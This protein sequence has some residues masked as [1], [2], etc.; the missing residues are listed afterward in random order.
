[1]SSLDIDKILEHWVPGQRW[2]GGKGRPIARIS[3]AAHGRL[4][5]EH[6][7]WLYLATV[8][9]SDGG[10]DQYF[11]PVTFHSGPAERLEHALIGEVTDEDGRAVWVYDAL[12]D[13]D[14]SPIWP[15]LMAEEAAVEQA[16]FHALPGAELPR[17]V[18]GD[19][20]TV[21]Q[22]NTSLVYGESV[23]MKFFRRIEPGRNPDVEIHEALS[24]TENPHLAPLLGY[25]T[26]AGTGSEPAT[27]AMAQTFMSV[28]S[29]GWAQ[30][31]A[32]V[33]DLFAEGDLHPQE[34]GGDFAGEAHR[35]GA[36]TASV[37]VD[38]AR[39]LPTRPVS[40][41]WITAE[42]AV[43][44]E[45]LTAAC[46]AVPALR[47]HEEALRATYAALTETESF[48][49]LQRIHGDLH[50]G[51]VLRTAIGW[52]ILDFEGEPARPMAQRREL[53]LPL[54]D[55]A[56][57]LR[58]FDY[59]A[60]S[61][62]ADG[63]QDAQLAYRATEWADRNRAAFCA[64]YAEEAG[65]DPLAQGPLL[66]AL[67]ADKAVYETMYEARNR[68]S[69]LWIPLSSLHRITKPAAEESHG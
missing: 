60:H 20:L 44:T 33:R 52:T 23:I 43:M 58:S 40:P 10:S 64:G 8:D 41:E 67:E 39:V 69:W 2:F 55:V 59:A 26:L 21:E 22:S 1:M 24:G 45:R 34:V 17:D 63:N 6:P 3:A 48:T 37:H 61:L 9:F 19:T 35:L 18:P 13:R 36:A 4:D 65:A 30:A 46:A 50:L 31:T 47:E 38:L 62:L 42:V 32:S 56:S 57:M 25:V 11:V 14:S 51:Q 5:P 29:D 54:R 68:P 7:L 27:V 49:P 28:A 66:R 15:R 16:A 12:H 53:S